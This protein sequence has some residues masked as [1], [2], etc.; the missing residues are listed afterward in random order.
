MELN[1]ADMPGAKGWARGNSG[2]IVLNRYE[3]Q[4]PDS[5]RSDMGRV[6]LRVR[7][8]WTAGQRLPGNYHMVLKSLIEAAHT[9]ETIK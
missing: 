8:L 9:R 7:L 2:V 4:I 6:L 5:Y 1:I 3:V